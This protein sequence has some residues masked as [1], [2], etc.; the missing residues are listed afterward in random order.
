MKKNHHL[1]VVLDADRMTKLN[2]QC[3]EDELT[4]SEACRLLVDA[5]LAGAI[6]IGKATAMPVD[7][8]R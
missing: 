7:E 5:Y 1:H 8:A 3:N 4:K 2:D 6:R